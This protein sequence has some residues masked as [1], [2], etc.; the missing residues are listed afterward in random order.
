[1]SRVGKL[2]VKIPEKVEVSIEKGN[3]V[4][5][6][7]PKGEIEKVIPEQVDIKMEDDS[8]SVSPKSQD[9][10]SRA[11]HGL[12]RALL[13]NM[14]L[15]VSQGFSKKLEISG[16]GYKAEMKGK[17]L[18]LNIGYSHPIIFGAGD[19]VKLSTP[20][21]N[22]IEISGIDKELVG[23]VAA[24]IRSFRKP[25]PYKGK[26]IRYENEYVRRKAGKAAGK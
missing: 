7:G 23:L 20:T 12:A 9:K 13:N 17:K 3:R 18:L 25:E 4:K 10:F 16:I 15:G 19:A 11:V 5:V 1:M 26:G 22:N 2:P 14:V 24:K 8:V 6:K 21:P